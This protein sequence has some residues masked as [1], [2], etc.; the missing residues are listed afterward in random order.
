MESSAGVWTHIR[1]WWALKV[2]TFKLKLVNRWCTDYGLTP[3]RIISKGT[4]DYIVAHDG[5]L[6]KVGK[7]QEKA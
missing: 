7:R 6:H 5:A 2:G 3:V 1:V 4:T